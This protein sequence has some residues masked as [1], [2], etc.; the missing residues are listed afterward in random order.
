MLECP[1]IALHQQ[2]QHGNARSRHRQKPFRDSLENMNG[3]H[4][5]TPLTQLIEQSRECAAKAST[6]NGVSDRLFRKA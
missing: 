5:L 1:R 6:T 2:N 4:V 3:V